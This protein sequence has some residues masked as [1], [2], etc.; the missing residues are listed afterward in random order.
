MVAAPSTPVHGQTRHG[1]TNDY[2]FV[3][4]PEHANDNRW[5]HRPLMDWKKLKQAESGKGPVA[6]LLAGVK[7]ILARRKS[8]PQL[9]SQVPTRIIETGNEK[10]FAFVRLADDGP[11]AG[12]FNFTDQWT[13]I[14]AAR[15]RREGLTEFKD[16]L[17]GGTAA[18]HADAL[19][20]APYGRLWLT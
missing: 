5:L 17:G 9:A 8:T 6:D 1:L 12:L 4:V 15:L 19:A 3:D 18:I 20:V 2:G 16:L 7:H 14:S 10:L 13:S 11:L